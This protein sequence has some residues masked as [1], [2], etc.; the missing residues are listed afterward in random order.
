MVAKKK[1]TAPSASS[2][3]ADPSLALQIGQIGGS[4]T[5]RVISGILSLA[6]LGQTYRLVDLTHDQRQKSGTLH[7]A[8]ALAEQAVCQLKW[9]MKPPPK[10][11]AKEKKICEAFAD[12][13]TNAED[14]ADF[15]AH[16]TGE[17]RLFGHATTEVIW[18]YD[19]KYLGP[20][21]FKTLHCRRFGFRGS[22]GKLVFTERTGMNPNEGIDL[23]QEFAPGNFVQARQRVNG[24]VQ[25]RE[26]LA[27]V[28]V[29]LAQGANWAY[30]DWMQLAELAW[31][32]KRLGKFKR[33]ATP[34]DIANLKRILLDIMTSGAAVHSEDVEVNLLW[35]QGSA[36]GGSSSKAVHLELL[37]WVL[38]ELCVA[39]I[40]SSDQLQP[41]ENGARAAVETRSENPKKIRDANATSL[42][43]TITR[44]L[45]VPFTKYNGGDRVRS[46]SFEFI[47]DDPADLEK[48]SK[49][50]LNFKNASVRI[51][52]KWFYETSNITP[53]TN[54]ERVLGDSDEPD[55]S[56]DPKKPSEPNAGNNESEPEE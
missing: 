5:P 22:D 32:P 13:Y 28:V 12:F 41:G 43:D 52:E 16:S 39:I 8:L 25:V 50:I 4:L 10:A 48:L 44:Q 49:A 11:S 27:R 7:A 9:Q 3:I 38:S 45:V 34:E 17:R 33:S 31:K 54:G 24:D 51:G 20:R 19:G 47:T 46:G 42:A 6:D 53:P 29:W 23:M 15:I 37:R 21:K 2:V 18:D 30:R 56:S 35:P 1:P 55:D 36:S 14:R 40:G 26:G